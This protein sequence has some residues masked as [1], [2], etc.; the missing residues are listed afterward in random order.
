MFLPIS[1][2]LSERID[3]KSKSEHYVFDIEYRIN[4]L[5]G[6]SGTGKTSLYNLIA[7]YNRGSSSIICSGH[8]KLQSVPTDS[9][10]E[11]VKQRFDNST[12]TLF[13][14][15]ETCK[16]LHT[17]GFEK[18]FNANNYYMLITR[19]CE[20]NNLPIH[21]DAFYCLHKSGRYLLLK[22]LYTSRIDTAIPDGYTQEVWDMM[23]VEEKE[24][25]LNLIRKVVE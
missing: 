1:T 19:D 3:I 10:L 9:T 20:F 25:V 7:N 12:N 14:I 13:V 5:V 15:D 21:R 24:E 18:T 23:T 6:D 4:I 17:V 11:E 22:Q 8:S 16:F 2:I